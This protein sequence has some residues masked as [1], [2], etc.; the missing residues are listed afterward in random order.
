MTGD[1]ILLR[2][3]AHGCTLYLWPT[4]VHQ[5]GQTLFRSTVDG[6]VSTLPLSFRKQNLTDELSNVLEESTF[7]RTMWF[8]KMYV[9]S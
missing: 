4:D 2:R 5:P 3:S 1:R 7:T 9:L 8:I 6:S